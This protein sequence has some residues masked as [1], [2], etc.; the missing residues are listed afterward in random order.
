[1]NEWTDGCMGGWKDG[2]TDGWMGVCVY[3]IVYII[4]LRYT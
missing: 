1:M 2:R 3:K 4:H